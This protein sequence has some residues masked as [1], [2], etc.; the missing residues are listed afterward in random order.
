[1]LIINLLGVLLIAAIVWW[2]WFY[3]P[4]PTQSTSNQIKILV[5][6]GIY[7]PSNIS[8]SADTKITLDFDRQDPAP[9]AETVIFPQLDLSLGLKMGQGNRIE[10]P[11]LS[12][13][14]YDFHCQMQMYKGKIISE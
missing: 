9:C 1:M 4:K 12:E 6:N 11:G 2:F 3:T 5:N 10:L 8:V 13:G 7:Q 14:E